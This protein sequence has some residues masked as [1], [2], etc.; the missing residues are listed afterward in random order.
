MVSGL[1]YYSWLN[2]LMHRWLVPSLLFTA[3]MMADCIATFLSIKLY[4]VE[5][6]ANPLIRPLLE[7]VG[8]YGLYALS[9]IAVFVV[10]VLSYVCR[11]N[12]FFIGL[13]Y[14]VSLFRFLTALATLVILYV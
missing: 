1:E 2:G 13:V 4:G 3:S 5:S 11:E 12:E 8:F 6:E 9:F 14:V 7:S 10:S